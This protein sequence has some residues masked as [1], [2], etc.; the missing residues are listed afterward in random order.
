[1]KLLLS[2]AVLTLLALPACPAEEAKTADVIIAE[3]DAVRNPDKP[4]SIIVSIAEY[5]GGKKRTRCR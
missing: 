1:M 5:R 3:A 2:A 4:F